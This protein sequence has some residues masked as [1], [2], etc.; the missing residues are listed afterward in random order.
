MEKNINIYTYVD[1][2]L[3]H[4]A[5]V[6]KLTEYHKST[7]SIFFK[8]ESRGPYWPTDFILEPL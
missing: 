6:L 2:K 8:K 4:F 3:N 1:I 7:L 5:V